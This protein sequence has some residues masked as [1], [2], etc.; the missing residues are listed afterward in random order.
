MRSRAVSVLTLLRL[1]SQ[2][3]VAL[4][5]FLTSRG[6]DAQ[7]VRGL[8]DSPQKSPRSTLRIDTNPSSAEFR[9]SAVMRSCISRPSILGSLCSVSASAPGLVRA[10][11][12]VRE[13]PILA[14]YNAR[15][16]EWGERRV[17]TKRGR[18]RAV[19]P[20]LVA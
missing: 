17:R 1:T 16:G 14:T 15:A 5:P 6:G 12:V 7:E 8:R 10:L 19:L 18:V 13:K 9:N 2:H 11:G 20:E 4:T 3:G